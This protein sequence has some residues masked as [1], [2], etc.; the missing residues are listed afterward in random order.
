MPSRVEPIAQ[1]K[2]QVIFVQF[3]EAR[4]EMLG[5]VELFG[6]RVRLELESPRQ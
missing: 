2:R 5:F 3:D 4:L 6:E 1:W